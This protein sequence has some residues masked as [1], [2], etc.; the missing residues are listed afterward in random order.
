MKSLNKNV[1]VK[2]TT[3]TVTHILSSIIS[4]KQGDLLGPILFT[5]FI[6]AIMITWTKMYD[7]PL[8]IFRTKQ[9]FILT[10]RRSTTR[11]FDFSRSM[12][13]L[14]ISQI[15]PQK[16]PSSYAEPTTFD[17]RN[18]QHI[19]LGT[20]LQIIFK[21]SRTSC[22]IEKESHLTFTKINQT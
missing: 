16:P 20:G 10:G 8:C 6:A 5:I 21:T 22:P 4:V 3:G 15:S 17:D 12:L 14:V 1:N 13:A 2:F 19:N 11:G 18:L 9:G 7:R